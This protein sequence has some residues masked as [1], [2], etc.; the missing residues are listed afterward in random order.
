[1]KILSID[2][3][4]KMAGIA[5]CNEKEIVSYPLEVIV[6]ENREVLVEKISNLTKSNGVE[7][8][9]V[10]LARNMDGSYGDKARICEKFAEKIKERLKMP[11]ALWDER[12]TTKLAMRY[13][14]ESNTK[15]K[16]KKKIVDSIAATIIL[17]SFIEYKKNNRINLV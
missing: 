16:K 1:M 10:G 3:G 11:V 5:I 6:E 15:K 4:E 14:N 12:Q 17:E 8:V 13:M 2:L 9:L 7:M